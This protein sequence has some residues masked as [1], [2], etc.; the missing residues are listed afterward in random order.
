MLFNEKKEIFNN[1]M[2]KDPYLSARRKDMGRM[3]SETQ[4]FAQARRRS[5]AEVNVLCLRGV[6]EEPFHRCNGP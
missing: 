6:V 5:P 3:G 2:K 4:L 1:T